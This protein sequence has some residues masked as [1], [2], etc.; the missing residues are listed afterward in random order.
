MK[1]S[2]LEKVCLKQMI[3]S[4]MRKVKFGQRCKAGS[5]QTAFGASF[6]I[7]YHHKLKKLEHLLHQDESVKRVFTPLPKVSYCSGRKLS[8]HLFGSKFY[9]LER[10]R[11]S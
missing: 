9:P 3:D 8:S 2:F 11:G 6:I 5:K 4:Q 1:S 7:K 10:K